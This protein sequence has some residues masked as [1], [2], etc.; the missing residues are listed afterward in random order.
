MRD[1]TYQMHFL[2]N[3]ETNTFGLD[4]IIAITSKSEPYF[5]KENIPLNLVSQS[6]VDFKADLESEASRFLIEYYQTMI[7]GRYQNMDKI[8]TIRELD[9]EDDDDIIVKKYE[10]I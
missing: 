3:Y 1:I 9:F 8:C 7:Q 10:D 5:A 6:F 4:I 2:M